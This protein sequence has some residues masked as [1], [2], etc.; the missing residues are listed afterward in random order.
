MQ[1]ISSVINLLNPKRQDNRVQNIS[2]VINLSNPKRQDNRVE[3]ISTVINLSNPSPALAAKKKKTLRNCCSCNFKG[4]LNP[5]ENTNFTNNVITI[6]ATISF[7]KFRTY[8]REWEKWGF[9]NTI[10]VWGNG[11][12]TKVWFASEVKQKKLINT[13]TITITTKPLF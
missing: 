9:K 7:S 13:L 4:Y 8:H 2:K 5:K 1:N 10:Y 12:W 11:L 6:L 3:N